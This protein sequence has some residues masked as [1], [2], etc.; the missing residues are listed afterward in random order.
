M[1]I[2]VAVERIIAAPRD[3][4]S[5]YVMDHGN[6]PSWIGGIGESEL[7]GDPPIA[8]G[9]RVRRV[10]SFLG[11]RIE[12]VNEVVRLEPDAVMEMRS[13]N[14][15]FPMEVSHVFEDAP[16]G[17]RVRV[18]VA[19][20]PAAWYRIGGPLLAAAV[21]RSVGGDLERLAGTLEQTRT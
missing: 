10:A 8:V 13:V 14:S 4:V 21:R 3:V 19:G 16:G 12:Y 1:S 5:S 9:S 17:T 15:P 2:D 6:D 7:L 20:E 11:R 18:H